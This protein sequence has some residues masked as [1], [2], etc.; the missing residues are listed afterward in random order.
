MHEQNRPGISLREMVECLRSI[1]VIVLQQDSNVW[2]LD[3]EA[4]MDVWVSDGEFLH[5]R[6]DDLDHLLEDLVS[7]RSSRLV[8]KTFG[9]V[10]M[11]GE[12][13]PGIL[14]CMNPFQG[15][16]SLEEVKVQMDLLGIEAR[17]LS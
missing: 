8:L 14:K 2:M 1:G 10:E 3:V 4:G 12:A 9:E 7:C 5:G 17:G 15:A 13:D 11:D 16:R 6:W